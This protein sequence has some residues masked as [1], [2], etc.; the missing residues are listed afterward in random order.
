MCGAGSPYAAPPNLA[1][2]PTAADAGSP[3][4]PQQRLCVPQV[5]RV[6]AFGELAVDR[7]EKVAALISPPLGAQQAD[8][9]DRGAQLEP[10]GALLS[11]DRQR[12][13]ITTLD[14]RPV[15]GWQPTQELA[16]QAVEL[17]NSPM[18]SGSLRLRQCCR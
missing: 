18:C 5:G 8:E 10:A 3:Q 7:R 4:F 12:S 17:C 11:R 6:E 15:G 1:Q 16:A 2:M 13:A 9:T 14:L